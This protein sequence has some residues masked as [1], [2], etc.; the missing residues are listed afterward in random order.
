M[1]SIAEKILAFVLLSRIVP[2]IHENILHGIKCNNSAERRNTDMVFVQ[3]QNKKKTYMRQ[4]IG[5]YSIFISWFK[6][7]DT[8]CKIEL[9]KSGNAGLSFDVSH[10]DRPDSWGPARSGNTP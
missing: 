9:E 6:T 8:R 2:T 7:F 3:S 1:L 5:L 4:N 10:N